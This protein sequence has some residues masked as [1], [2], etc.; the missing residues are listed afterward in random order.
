MENMSDLAGKMLNDYR[1]LRR[2]G[3]GAMAEVFLAEQSSLGRQV[4]LK[5]LN[6]H[7]ANDPNYVQRF[8]QEARA[9]AALIHAGIVQIYEVG[10][11]EGFHFIA[12]EYVPGRNLGELILRQGRVAPG[13][14][15]D[16]LRQVTGAL[17]KASEHGIVHRDIKPENIMLASSGEVKVADFGLARVQGEQDGANLTQVGVTMGTPLYM[18][19]EQIEGQPLDSRSDI[20]SLGVTAYHMLSGRPPYEGDTP[21]SVVVQHLNQ[22]AEPLQTRIADLPGELARVV[23]RML[24]KKAADRY[25]NPVELLAELRVVASQAASQGWGSGAYGWSTATW[26]VV[27]PGGSDAT[28]HLSA[29]MK[30]S[31]RN[32]APRFTWWKFATV[33]LVCFLVGVGLAVLSR[34]GSILAGA[35]HQTPKRENVTAQIYH[36]KRVDTEAAWNAIPRYFPK[37]DVYEINLARQGLVRHY[38]FVT[39]EF[40]KAIPVLKRLRSTSSPHDRFNRFALAGLTIASVRQGALKEARQF[41]QQITSTDQSRLAEEDPDLARQFREAQKKLINQ[42]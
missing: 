20:Y 36:A 18:S 32:K 17:Q 12:Q 4:A 27:V 22:A 21:L 41:A 15:L 16:I 25:A 19:P 34:S 28:R 23:H 39:G 37:A 3:R 14:T 8:H 31:T 2:L 24:A 11:A 1:V 33:V 26:P 10:Q 38:F 6:L 35:Q 13:Q 5:V 9:A 7:L 29:V 42:G 40:S 30:T